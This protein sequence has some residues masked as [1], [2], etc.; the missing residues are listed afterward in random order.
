MSEE[1]IEDIIN[2]VVKN[3]QSTASRTILRR[4]KI[5]NVDFESSKELAFEIK[6][7]LQNEKKDE[8]DFCFYLVK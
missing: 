8:V 5:N 2:F 4:F 1:K 6:E 3:P 7:I